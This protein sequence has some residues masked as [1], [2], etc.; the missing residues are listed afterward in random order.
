MLYRTPKIE[1]VILPFKIPVFIAFLKQAGIPRSWHSSCGESSGSGFSHW[2]PP[3]REKERVMFKKFVGNT[4]VTPF[5]MKV[6]LPNFEDLVA[7]AER[8]TESCVHPDQ[9]I[10]SR[11]FVLNVARR[12]W[13]RKIYSD[14]Q[15][16]M[17]STLVDHMAKRRT[18]KIIAQSP[19][20]V[21]N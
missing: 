1:K 5:E 8:L 21:L 19:E 11:D 4:E 10:V 6:D 18:R 13:E 9:V 2:H 14:R 16:L 3:C 15:V 7:R 20:Q 17:L 12:A